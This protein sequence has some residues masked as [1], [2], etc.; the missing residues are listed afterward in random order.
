MEE[1]GRRRKRRTIKI[2]KGGSRDISTFR[3][4]V[5]RDQLFR[6]RILGSK[7]QISFNF[8]NKL[9]EELLR[10]RREDEMLAAE[11]DSILREVGQDP[12]QDEICMCCASGCKSAS[13]STDSSLIDLDSSDMIPEDIDDLIIP[14]DEYYPPIDSAAF[15]VQSLSELEEGGADTGEGQRCKKKKSNRKHWGWPL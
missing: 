14:D 15:E 12:E 10:Y 1:K 7:A 6:A 2:V 4:Q 11:I 5:A 8:V 9:I 13:S 3:L